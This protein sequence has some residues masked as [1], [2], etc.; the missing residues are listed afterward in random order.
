MEK[1]MD[2]YWDDV[3]DEVSSALAITWGRM[4]QNLCPDGC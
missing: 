1:T 2:D 4:P 3:A